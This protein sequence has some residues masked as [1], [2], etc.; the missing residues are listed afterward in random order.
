M[1]ISEI[2]AKLKEKKHLSTMSHITN[3]ELEIHN[4][5]YDSRNN[6]TPEDSLFFAIHT[7]GGNDGHK[8]ISQLYKSGIKN[9][10]AEYLPEDFETKQDV[11]IIIVK[12]VI[13]ALGVIGSI[14]RS[15][16]KEVVAITGS[17]G[18]TTLKE[19]IF[20]LMEPLVNISRSP[21]SFN[22]KIGVPFSLWQI[23]PQSD[24]ALIEAG[25][26]KKGEMQNLAEIIK[27]DTV[28]FTNIGDA[29]ANGFYSIKEKTE[30]K[31]L[32]A[33]NENVK[34]VIYPFD[35]AF[36]RESLK[37]LNNS[38][39]L[40]SWSL[41]NPSADVYLKIRQKDK[42]RFFIEYFWK[43]KKY[44]ITVNFKYDYNI[45]N[46]AGALTFM[47]KE[48]ISHEI[49]RER[50]SKLQRIDTR[51]NVSEGING[52]SLILDS[53][54]SDL[55]SLLPAIDFMN[56][57]KMP[58]QSSTLIISDLHHEVEKSDNTYQKIARIVRE[59]GI[60]RFIGVGKV[61]KTFS[62]LFPEGSIFFINTNELL[63]H[64][65]ASDFNEEIILLKGSP[66]FNFSKIREQL[67][68]KKH[69]TVLE[70]NLDAMLRNYNY[71]RSKLYPS[72]GIICMVK[73][74][75]YGAGSYEIAKTLQDAGASYLAVAAL[76]E[77]I[78]LRKRGITS[79]VMIMNPRA[80][81]YLSLFRHGLEPVV[82]S[83]AMLRNLSEQ[84][85]KYGV[86]EYPIHIKLD[87]GMHRMGFLPEETKEL[88]RLLTKS[89]DIKIATVF[90]HLATAD[91]M[92]MDEYTLQQI[93]RF[94]EMSEEIMKNTPYPVK[95]HILN[96][97]GILRF[98]DY[99]YDYVRLGIGLYGANTL[100]IEI[101]KPLS[102]VS[103]LRT[104]I[105]C[106]RE[107][108]DP[109]AVG[110]GRKGSIKG[111]RK[112]ATLPIGYAD[113]MNRHF[114]NGAIKVFI[115][116]QKA[117]TIGNICM[118][119]TMI[120]VTGIECKEGDSVEIFG[121]KMALQ[122]L[123]DSLET[124]PYEILTSVSPRVKRVYYRE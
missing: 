120:D 91:C 20:Q 66:E 60:K 113:G 33:K 124:I 98:S 93:K 118:D 72:T 95:R 13:N 73:A 31:S 121:E 30:E 6:F 29:H 100:P 99:Q 55:S 3:P 83:L 40:I 115:N 61:M 94:E 84:A 82:Y 80:E 123:A 111:K 28:I 110:Y 44:D 34:V 27:P 96:S 42:E 114:G 1:K 49:I 85:S 97:A 90:S 71:F 26:S 21:R 38:K 70:V 51:L 50:F 23:A 9:F 112:I 103:T 75:G 45:E 87:T 43:D 41:K 7:K 67:E 102:V 11:N 10:V 58:N 77:G 12:D 69:E 54:T 37:S 14:K 76:D 64:L 119:A 35:S 18:K 25:I 63:S 109:E 57:R 122:S 8:F 106:I 16:A 19:M 107:I 52:C 47:L 48:G 78:E 105:I 81:N 36:I 5:L 92:D 104:V 17:R 22:S 65:S 86:G 89:K 24:L 116:G 46:I 32:L 2:V 117:P 4:L 62:H 56:R 68:A 101:E 39:K 74:F 53:Y 79:P 88:I 15:L 108:E 59:T